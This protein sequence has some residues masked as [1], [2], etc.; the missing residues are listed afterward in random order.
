MPDRARPTFF[1]L[2][3]LI[4][5]V[6]TFALA[7]SLLLADAVTPAA[8]AEALFLSATRGTSLVR[9]LLAARAIDTLRLEQVLERG[10][11]PYM[12]HISPVSTLV[13]RLPPGVC[14]RLL[15]IPVRIDPRTGTVDVAVVDARDPHPAE[16][17]SYWLK[18]PVRVVRTSI[19][20]MEAALLRIV[21]RVEAEPEP[22]L[23]MRALAPPIW[24]PAPGPI[25]SSLF[26]TPMY[27]STAFDA[28]AATLEP[29]TEDADIAFP[30]TRRHLAGQRIINLGA[31]AVEAI[32]KPRARSPAGRAEADPILDL[33]R[34]K[35]SA[36]SAPLPDRD[37]PPPPTA[38][39]PFPSE[40]A[41]ALSATARSPSAASPDALGAVVGRMAETQDRDEILDLLVAGTRAV[42]RRA[43]VF[44]VR[45][46]AL[47]G[48]TCSRDLAERH[49]LRSV[50][51][52]NALPTVL[53]RAFE[54][55][56]PTLTTL[57][58]DAAHAP[59]VSVMRSPP[60]GQVVVA[61]VM[62]EGKP[63]AVVFADGVG[64]PT[65]A[66]ERI[67]VLARAAGEALGR[68]LRERREK[69]A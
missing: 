56:G 63:V 54:R 5:A 48:W 3:G 10:E 22:E 65:P 2:S 64:E 14:D 59:L 69:S 62:A 52:T 31:P 6:V 57:P 55:N 43:G 16:E 18:A 51:L 24:T 25:P 40:P 46:D 15:A 27:G 44:A 61:A 67:G 26:R 36:L 30:L 12:R 11:A 9:T 19:A 41:Q 23:G 33:K 20:T 58:I 1:Q 39:G 68:L 21:A 47:T 17:L 53:H 37:E 13:D 38:R 7:R 50:R 29:P 32:E 42:A 49:A 45:R 34:R 66:L 28:A 4:S 8:L 60:S 35:T